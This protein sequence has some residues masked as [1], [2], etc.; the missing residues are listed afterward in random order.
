MEEA[1]RRRLGKQFIAEKQ[2]LN[3]PCRH[4]ESVPPAGRIVGYCS[5]VSNSAAKGRENFLSAKIPHNPLKM[6][7]SDE[8]IQGNPSFSNPHRL[9]FS[10]P[11]GL[12]PRKP[13]PGRPD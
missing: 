1:R 8:G 4:D 6:L 9:G 7:D 11:N 5:Q 2:K 13:K 10:R 3:Y 12:I